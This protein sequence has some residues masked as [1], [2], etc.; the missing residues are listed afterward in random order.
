MITATMVVNR[1]KILPGFHRCREQVACNLNNT[2]IKLNS[3]LG[4]PFEIAINKS[5]ATFVSGASKRTMRAFT[6]QKD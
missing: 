4:N 6:Y 2:Q 5:L 1:T 3:D